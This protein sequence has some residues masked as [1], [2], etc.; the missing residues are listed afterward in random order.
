MRIKA[1]PPLPTMAMLILSLAEGPALPMLK[2]GATK[3]LAPATAADVFRNSRLFIM[4][5]FE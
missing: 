4:C 5:S 3:A 1:I 2:L